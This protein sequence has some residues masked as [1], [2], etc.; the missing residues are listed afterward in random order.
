MLFP[1]AV[2]DCNPFSTAISQTSLEHDFDPFYCVKI[3]S[4]EVGMGKSD[5]G[6]D[7][8]ILW[9]LLKQKGIDDNELMILFFRVCY[10]SFFKLSPFVKK[11][12]FKGT[13]F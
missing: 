1:S 7:I 3:G 13:F 6:S 12:F 10:D 4:L 5:F 2:Q 8:E 9:N 11:I